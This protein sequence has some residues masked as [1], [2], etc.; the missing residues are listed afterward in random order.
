MPCKITLRHYWQA[1]KYSL[2][3]CI[4]KGH[5]IAS[6][7]HG[8]ARGGAR[9]RGGRARARAHRAGLGAGRGHLQGRA[10]LSNMHWMA[11]T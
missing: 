2:G 9:T 10:I 11:R 5:V 8:R 4:Q 1:Y 7:H 6:A 3:A